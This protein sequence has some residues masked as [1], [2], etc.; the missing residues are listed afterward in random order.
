MRMM[1]T[2]T[3]RFNTDCQGTAYVSSGSLSRLEY[4]GSG[5]LVKRTTQK[6]GSSV[7]ANSFYGQ[8]NGVMQCQNSSEDTITSSHYETEATSKSMST[9]YQQAHTLQWAN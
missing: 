1:S 7:S 5:Y 2:S 9:Y 6:G 3:L 4:S 8:V